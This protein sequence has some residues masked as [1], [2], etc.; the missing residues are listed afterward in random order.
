MHKPVTVRKLRR[1]LHKYHEWRS[2]HQYL[3]RYSVEK[4]LAFE[5]YCDNAS[6]LRVTAVLLLTPF[7]GLV[8]IMLIATIPLNSPLAGVAGNT[9]F[10]VHLALSYVLMSVGLLLF[11]RCALGWPNAWYSHKQMIIISFLVCACNEVV[12][13]VVGYAWRFPVPFRDLLGVFPYFDFLGIFHVLIVGEIVFLRCQ[14]QLLRY[15]PLLMVQASTLVIF[16]AYAIVFE[17]LSTEG[18]VA[19][20]ICFPLLKVIIKR[21]AWRFSA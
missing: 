15:V 14:S 10:Y 1:V 7:P 8:A 21:M 3:G 19:L 12:F 11:I 4:L 6:A 2:G 13:V 5:N 20:T 16:Q 9:T 18:Q 17:H